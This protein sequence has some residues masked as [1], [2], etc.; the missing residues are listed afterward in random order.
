MKHLERKV[1]GGVIVGLLEEDVKASKP[2]SPAVEPQEKKPVQRK[3]K[4]EK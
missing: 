2:I 1:P 3:R 4:A